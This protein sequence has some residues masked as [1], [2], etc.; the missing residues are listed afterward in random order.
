MNPPLAP[1]GVDL[2]EQL[3]R[4][5]EAAQRA[6]EARAAESEATS[7]A[8]AIS[9]VEPQ[10]PAMSSVEQVCRLADRLAAKAETELAEMEAALRQW[11]ASAESCRQRL[12][13]S[14]GPTDAAA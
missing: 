4:A 9:V 3:E 14:A 11:L 10:P 1:Q 6:A 2:L 12:E 8:P 5:V 7:A 13:Q